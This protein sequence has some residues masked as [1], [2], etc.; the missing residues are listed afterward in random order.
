VYQLDGALCAARHL[1]EAIGR[2]A[3]GLHP[4][5]V[6]AVE[7]LIFVCLAESPPDFAHTAADLTAFLKPHGLARTKVCH[8]AVEV[9]HANWKV[10]AENFWECYHC[11]A[12]HPEFCSVMSYAHAQDSERL[13]QERQEFEQDWEAAARSDGFIVGNI[14]YSDRGLHRGGRLPIRPGYL[15]QS[16]DGKP[17]AP[18]LGE[19][20]SYDGGITSFM[21]FPIIWYVV[22]N[23]YALLTRFTP[24]SPLETELELT[25][26]VHQDAAEGRDYDT[27]RVCWLWRVTAEQ[28]RTICE[29]NQR[30]I[31]SSR[32]QPGPYATTERA[33]DEFMTWYLN[34]LNK[35]TP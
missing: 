17:V 25:W 32:Y 27:E 31:L 33:C 18:L 9:I 13:A 30:G 6:R 29:N 3:L 14:E 21:H 12:T 10:A 26:L 35:E 15:T 7:G 16:Q 4:V 28:D 22:N 8:R 2:R 5:H 23:D 1:P 24:V 20:T 34:E 19:Y 11:T